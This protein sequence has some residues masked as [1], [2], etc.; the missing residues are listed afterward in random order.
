ML[1]LIIRWGERDETI[2]E[3]I[4][5]KGYLCKLKKVKDKCRYY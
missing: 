4:K 5:K 3:I 2:N 1:F